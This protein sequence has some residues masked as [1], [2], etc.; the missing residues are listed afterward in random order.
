[1]KIKKLIAP[2]IAVLAL[3][4]LSA[5]TQSS[6]DTNVITMK[7]DT[8]TV[9]D[10]FNEGKTF[11][12]EG[13]SQMLQDLTFSKIFE[14]EYGKQVTSAQVTA[15]FN[16]TKA[17][18]GTSFDSVLSQQGFTEDNFSIYLRRQLL[19][20]A[21]ID[22]QAKATQFTTANL[23]AAWKTYH[24]QVEALILSFSTKT[25]AQNEINSAKT[26]V[27][28]FVSQSKDKKLNQK[29]DS[30]STTVPAEVKTAA[31]KLKNGEFSAPV[32]ST[33]ATTGA[34]TYY[35]VYML[36]QQ[37]KGTDMNKYKTQLQNIILAQ[38]E[39]DTSFVSSVIQSYLNKYAV[40]IKVQQFSNLFAN[41]APSSS[42]TASK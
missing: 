20:K 40:T 1:M 34:V 36:T 33:D 25:D 3:V 8:I 28:S 23:E 14:K 5:C 27:D 11:P 21:A 38:K 39:Q 12:S 31:F 2:L 18:Y 4:T 41:Y 30:T 29:F 32:A 15:E 19:Q 9:M 42:T 10:V 6:P 26:N 22:A 17:Q 24:P 16:K 13:T 7:G 35:V 37:A